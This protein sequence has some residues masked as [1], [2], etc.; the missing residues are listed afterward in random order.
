MKKYLQKIGVAS[1]H[2]KEQIPLPLKEVKTSNAAK[3]QRNR[4]A[5]NKRV[6]L[7]FS[8]EQY[9]LVKANADGHSMKVAPFCK[10]ATLA[11][12]QKLFILPDLEVLHKLEVGIKRIGNNVNQC[13][14]VANANRSINHDQI[15]QI[16]RLVS[17]LE[18]LVNESL[19]I[20][21][22]LESLIKKAL[23]ERPEFA[24]TLQYLIEN[25]DN[26]SEDA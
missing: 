1:H 23:S 9:E 20:P 22:D 14:F 19:T 24:T 2:S 12:F 4:R 17:E 25:H 7:Y 8:P 11:Y 16:A 3:R 15:K 21:D 10:A 6:E 18:V 26:Q 13:A 5:K